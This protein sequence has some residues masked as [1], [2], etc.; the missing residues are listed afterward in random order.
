VRVLL[1]I[2]SLFGSAIKLDPVDAV[3]NAYE[4]GSTISEKDKSKVYSGLS[5]M[6]QIHDE[7]ETSEQ[8]YK[9]LQ[10]VFGR[11]N[12]NE[13]ELNRFLGKRD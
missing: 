6:N 3:K 4:L 12:F 11:L 13:Q 8:F 1:N 9:E 7:I 2:I 5:F 10:R